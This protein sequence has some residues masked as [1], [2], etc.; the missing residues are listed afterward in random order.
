[1]KILITTGIFPPDIGGP[2]HY[3]PKIC[4]ELSKMNH[5]VEIVTLSEKNGDSSDC[6]YPVNR[7]IRKQSI[8]VRI[9]KTI[10]TIIKS[11]WNKD[12]V[13]CNGLAFETILAS[14]ISFKPVVC[15]VVGDFAWE[16][17][18]NRG[19]F[20][21]TIDEFQESSSGFRNTLLKWYR[22]LPLKMA[23][24]VIVPSLYLKKIVHGWGVDEK[25]IHVVYNALEYKTEKKERTSKQVKTITTV[26]RL[27]PWKGVEGII[28]VVI[29]IS[30]VR[31]III[32]DGPCR[33]RL[34][35]SAEKGGISSRTLFTGSVPKEKV[36]EYIQKTDLFVL[37]SSYEGLPHVILEAM[38][39]GVP[40]VATDAGGTG[41]VVK[42]EETGLLVPVDD[43][44]ALGH[45][46][47][48]VL[49]EAG[50]TM[51]YI[52]NASKF[53]DEHFSYPRMIKETTDVLSGVSG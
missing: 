13:Y 10:F 29:G 41:E 12:C 37:N 5:E 11:S 2:A 32:G 43:D 30:D 24:R 45:A 14:L 4:E 53:V 6:S 22:T 34:E 3:V 9:I 15:K 26:C 18:V 17:S 25:Q 42:H 50:K 19:W 38:A 49:D 21:G 7:I 36:R 31:L 40:V 35:S 8:P 46:I 52:R 51:K 27:V 47:R 48:Q 39:A 1:M 44:Q 16:R 20:K 23:K 33:K 28:R